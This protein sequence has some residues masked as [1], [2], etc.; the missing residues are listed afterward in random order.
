MTK[1]K[2]LIQKPKS[3]GLS[4]RLRHDDAARVSKAI[5]ESQSGNTSRVYSAQWR[6]FVA[7]CSSDGRDYAAMPAA[8][9]TVAAY[10]STIASSNSRYVARAAISQ[11]HRIA[12]EKDDAIEDPTKSMVVEKTDKGT[13]R[14]AAK[15][16][17]REKKAKPL[18]LEDMRRIVAHI[19]ELP[20]DKRGQLDQRD[21]AIICAGWWSMCRRDEI[22]KWQVQDVSF[23]DEGA[24]V[25]MPIT[26]TSQSAQGETINLPPEA[27]I[28]LSEYIGARRRGPVFLSSGRHTSKQQQLDGKDIARIL[29]RWAERAGLPDAFE[30][31]G[32]S[33]RRGSIT[34]ASN[35]GI[36]LD[37][38][39]D[40][41]R[42]ATLDVLRGYIKESPARTRELFKAMGAKDG[43]GE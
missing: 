2:S 24:Q 9:E 32:H 30:L 6:K 20:E 39:A 18:S 16:G 26:K 33:L 11:A 37:R 7:W 17:S 36:P 8:P 4:T 29:K 27:A 12:K 40:Q 31:S 23:N 42:H 14:I 35:A 34:H 28:R 3:A 19:E 38:I 41:S 5:G 25:F 22:A 13:G 21:A 10:L 1:D 43:K 15:A